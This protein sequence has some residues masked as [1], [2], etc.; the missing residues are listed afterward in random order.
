MS[1][2]HRGAIHPVARAV[3]PPPIRAPDTRDACV[4]VIGT[5][6]SGVE[7]I[8]GPFV[9]FAAAHDY[10]RS[11]DHTAHDLTEVEW[12]I[13]QLLPPGTDSGIADPEDLDEDDE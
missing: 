13:V 7:N 5:L 12:F 10:A 9:D 11:G 6:E 1:A 4:I 3:P 2:T 8:V